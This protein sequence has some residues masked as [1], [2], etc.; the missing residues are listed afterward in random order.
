MKS[1]LFI[2]DNEAE[3]CPWVGWL[4]F[5]WVPPA[6]VKVKLRVEVTRGNVKL[7]SVKTSGSDSGVKR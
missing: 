5:G 1:V 2:L 4:T 7:V 3:P 6:R